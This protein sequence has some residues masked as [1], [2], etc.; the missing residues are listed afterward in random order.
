MLQRKRKYRFGWGCHN[1]YLS[2][3]IMLIILPSAAAVWKVKITQSKHRRDYFRIKGHT[4][5]LLV[6]LCGLQANGSLVDVTK[7]IIHMNQGLLWGI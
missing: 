7:R 5:F 6:K 1:M 2:R 3:G 4:P